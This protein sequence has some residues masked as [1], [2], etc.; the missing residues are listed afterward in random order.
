[1]KSFTKFIL[2]VIGGFLAS[3]VLYA[4]VVRPN[5][6]GIDQLFSKSIDKQ[7]ELKTVGEQ[8]TAYKNSQ[9]DL[10]AVQN[11]DR[12]TSAIL[13]RENL[14]VAVQEIEAAATASGV[15]S[16]ISIHDDP[17]TLKDQAAS[18]VVQDKVKIDEIPYTLSVSGPYESVLKFIKY[19]EH[20]PHFTEISQIGMNAT[21]TLSSGETTARHDGSVTSTIDAVFFIKSKA[22][23]NDVVDDGSAAA[24]T[25][26]TE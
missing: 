20:L 25:E 18:P 5:I 26:E 4:M 24:P 16:S 15:E 3:V 8:I 21:T 11:K 23:L 22:N 17:A 9:A 2:I 14:E 1:M 6:A 19:L 12:I 10:N 7:T 13:E